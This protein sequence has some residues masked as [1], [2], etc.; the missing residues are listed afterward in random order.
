MSTRA[1]PGHLREI[2]STFSERLRDGQSRLKPLA[3]KNIEEEH[4]SRFR[5]VGEHGYGAELAHRPRPAKKAAREYSS[6]R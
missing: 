4:R 1:K 3:Y 6:P 2:P 5:V